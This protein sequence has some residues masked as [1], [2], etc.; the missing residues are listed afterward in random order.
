MIGIYCDESHDD[1]TYTLAGWLG[2]PAGWEQFVPAWRKMLE[3]FP[4]QYF[5]ASE[6]VN[7]DFDENSRY[8]GWTFDD[9]KRF[10][11]RAVDVVCDDKNACGW[12]VPV[13]VSVSLNEHSRWT[14]TPETAWKLLFVRLFMLVLNRFQ[15][16]NGISFVFHRKPEV[17]NYV[18]RFYDP[19]KL[20]INEAFPG[21]LHGDMV[22]FANDEEAGFEP[23]QAAD[24]LVYEWRRRITERLAQPEKRQRTS[25]RRIREARKRD[26]ELHHYD[27]AAV[28]SILAQMATKKH[29][30]EA[31][32]RCPSTDE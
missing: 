17:K 19:A 6:L 26:A 4:V 11:T 12:M 22:G 21:K 23:L 3:E 24:L 5:H 29:F 7:R 16:Q 10:F 1:H 18:D 20:V 8:K 14:S 32:M 28:D 27:A 30:V 13:G 31:M 2:S 25:Y 9:E 15:A